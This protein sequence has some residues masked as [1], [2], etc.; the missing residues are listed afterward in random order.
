MNQRKSDNILHSHNLLI[1]NQNF[2]N[3]IKTIFRQEGRGN[4]KEDQFLRYRGFN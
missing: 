3:N 4:G 1:P 2:G